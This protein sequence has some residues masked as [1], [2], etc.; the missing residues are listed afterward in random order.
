MLACICMKYLECKNNV[1]DV[2]IVY[3][4]CVIGPSLSKPHVVWS[5]LMVR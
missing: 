1:P 4:V 3:Q 5:T 2:A